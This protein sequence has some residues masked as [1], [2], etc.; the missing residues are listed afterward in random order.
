MTR[1]QGCTWSS[2]DCGSQPGE[3]E[4]QRAFPESREFSARGLSVFVLF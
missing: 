4:S 1:L 3:L 2:L